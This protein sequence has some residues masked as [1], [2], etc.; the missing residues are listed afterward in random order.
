M[1][2]IL[3]P[4]HFEAKD[5]LAGLESRRKWR[6]GAADCFSGRA[7]DEDVVVGIIGMGPPHAAKRAHAVI[8]E[9]KMENGKWKNGMEPIRGVILCGFAG[10]LKPGLKRGEIFVT[11]GAEYFLPHLPET[12]RP[13]V[14]KLHTA[15]AVAA[16]GAAKAEL[17]ARTGAWLVDMEQADIARV[18]AAAG[19]PFVGLRIVSDEAH[20]DLPHDL[21]SR[22]YNQAEGEYTPLKL[23]GHLTRNPFRARRLASFVRPL[24]PVRKRMSDHLHRWLKLT[25]PKLFRP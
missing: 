15:E 8:N 6:A 14:A 3:I 16:T 21:L 20:E 18:A 11:A 22:A 12:E 4:S 17:F 13:P 23:A 24:P 10:G 9:W 7:G 5:F 2:V 1:I 19:L 25:G